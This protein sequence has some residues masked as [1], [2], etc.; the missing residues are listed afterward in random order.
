M[1]FLMT[2]IMLM[3]I[4]LIV[5][6]ALN[7]L[8]GVAGR[9]S[10]YEAAIMGVGAYTSALL[11]QNLGVDLL[12][13]CIAGAIFCAG[14]G[15]LFQVMTRYMDFFT[16]KITSFALQMTLWQTFMTWRSVTKG[17]NGIYGVPRPEIFGVSF[18]SMT[19]YFW[20]TTALSAIAIGGLL[21]IERSQFALA[22]RGLRDGED[23]LES[24]GKNPFALKLK[25]FALA[26]AATGFA[27][28][29]LAGLMQS[30]SPYSFYVYVSVIFIIFVIAGG[31]GNLLGTVVAVVVLTVIQES[32]KMIPG[33]PTT[34]TAPLQQIF[35]GVVL[36]AAITIRPAGILPE[37]PII[38]SDLLRRAAGALPGFSFLTEPKMRRERA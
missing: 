30:V 8:L 38:R 5:S 18:S 6:L 4:Y 10:A 21:Y 11:A 1:Y 25:V 29:L 23:A 32:I 31:R 35:Y 3:E 37:K 34:W 28:G 7:L 22:L 20:L 26:G 9:F 36:I 13:G 2:T 17:S 27:G 19:A 16:F 15:V 14:I 12:V 33:L 24:L